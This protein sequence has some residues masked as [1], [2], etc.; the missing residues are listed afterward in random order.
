MDVNVADELCGWDYINV[1]LKDLFV[2]PDFSP[3]AVK[4]VMSMLNMTSAQLEDFW[5]RNNDA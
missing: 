4:M 5:A 1:P 2:H 3:G